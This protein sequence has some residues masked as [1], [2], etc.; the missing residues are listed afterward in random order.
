MVISPVESLGARVLRSWS[1][2][3]N[4]ILFSWGGGDGEREGEGGRPLS[5]LSLFPGEGVGGGDGEGEKGLF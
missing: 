2:L 4:L 3:S 1:R 5:N